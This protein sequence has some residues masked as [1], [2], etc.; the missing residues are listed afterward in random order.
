MA[1]GT[2]AVPGPQARTL[3][4]PVRVVAMGGGTGLSTLLKGLKQYVITDSS[5][6]EGTP[7]PAIAELA[8]IVTVTD[9]GGSSGRLRR[10]FNILP[11][12]DIRNCIA[13]LSEDEALL[14]RLFQHRFQAG[15]GLDGHSFGNLF[16]AALTSITG[17]FA[18]AVKLSSEIL[19]TR[20]HIY[21][22]TIS[23]VQLEAVMKD[24]STVRGETNI[25]AS[26]GRI[27][28]LRLLPPD[29]EPLA[30]TLQA[31]AE[32]DLIT[33]GPGSLFT[34]LVPNLL[35][36]G[37]PE[38]VATSRAVKVFV[39]NLMTEANESLGL[40]AADH[41]RVLNTHAGLPVFDCALVN[42]KPVSPEVAANYAR[43][44]AAQ[45]V[46][47]AAAIDALGVRAIL[48]DYLEEADGVARH[49]TNRVALD[50]LR[51]A[52]ARRQTASSMVQ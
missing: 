22:S 41:I 9:D 52:V 23:D 37:I 31:I 40:T 3:S 4:P 48:G 14:S 1:Q 18:E 11:P 6:A 44:R 26:T 36:R 17:D 7:A 33:I 25:T 8:A 43:E 29:V 30:E 27:V 2:P 5:A 24:G 15:S 21:P 34:S 51:M 49:A 45:I 50:L 10:D 39:C 12:G 16:L 42:Q 46:P 47:D 35:V 19:A 28:E 38:A 13:A 20:G 32:A